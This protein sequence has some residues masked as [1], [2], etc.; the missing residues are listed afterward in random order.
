M[1][2]L[3]TSTMRRPGPELGSCTTEKKKYNY[4][5]IYNIYIGIY[6]L[7][8]WDKF[9]LFSVLSTPISVKFIPIV[10]TISVQFIVFIVIVVI[11]DSFL[12]FL[13]PQNSMF[14]WASWLFR[15]FALCG[16]DNL[17]FRFEAFFLELSWSFGVV[18][19]Y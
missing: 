13:R 1:C 19:C 9:S 3:E 2:N 8:I 11:T 12:G 16:R 5:Y 7:F 17:G 4:I 10:G 15:H 18:C 14:C 6:T